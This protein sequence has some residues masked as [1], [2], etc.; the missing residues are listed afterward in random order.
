MIQIDK[1]SNALYGIVG[2]RQ[3]Y[4][5]KY[6]ILDLDNQKSDSGIYI[7]DNSYVNIEYI[8]DTVN[9]ANISNSQINELL[10]NKQKS[11]ICNVCN[12]VF[13]EYDFIDRNVL[14]S[15]TGNQEELEKL[16]DG[17]VGYKIKVSNE[18]NVAFNINRVF[19][20]FDGIGVFTLVLWNTNKKQIIESKQISIVSDNQVE[21]L[22]WTLNN[23]STTYKGDYYIGYL[24]NRV[25]IR[26]FKKGEFV[27]NSIKNIVV[28][29]VKVT[30]HN[31]LDIF[32]TK[33]VEKH[34]GNNGLNLDI[35]VYY[36]F[37]DFIINNKLMF[38]KAIS[39]ELTIQCLQMYIS[40]SRSNVNE[41]KA[42]ELYQK[43]TLE[44]EGTKEENSIVSVTGLRKLSFGEIGNLKS[45]IK[46]LQI[47]FYKKR[48]ISVNTLM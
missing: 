47:G 14:F 43:I 29:S 4:D 11:S 24:T 10:K 15:N 48:M 38:A 16:P 8:K 28:E 25:T 1:I 45:E 19:L 23:T 6:D 3:S 12:Q 35:V 37:T 32:N 17:F 41:R 31:S 26:P 13:S 42:Q 18:K 27:K 5:P 34:D 20:N 22:N 21:E 30:N 46:K 2:F 39:L 40:G 33:N 44:I 9:Y 36:D 7:T